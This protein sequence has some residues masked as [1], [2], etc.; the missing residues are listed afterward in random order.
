MYLDID[1]QLVSRFR[2]ALDAPAPERRQKEQVIQDFLEANSE[3]IPTPAEASP[4][5]HLDAIISKFRLTTHLTTDYV[6]LNRNSAAWDVTLVE[7]E[8]PDKVFFRDSHDRALPTRDFNDALA[9]VEDWQVYIKNNR[10]A[11]IDALRP[12]MKGALENNP[13]T[14]RFQLVYGRSESKNSS[15]ARKEYILNRQSGGIRILSYD[16]FIGLYGSAFRFKK[17]ILRQSKHRYAFKVMLDEPRH[18]FSALGPEHLNI[19]A[20]QIARLKANGYD[21]D[22]WKKGILLGYG[23]KQP[24][25]SADQIKADFLKSFGRS[26]R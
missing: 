16:S 6:Y 26:R 7:L 25:P 24:L 12:I 14:F 15:D 20:S 21:M 8:S 18:Y 5:L 17:N 11:V 22:S 4:A 23:D 9:Q 2:T 1:D 10:A 13:V 19:S 3:L